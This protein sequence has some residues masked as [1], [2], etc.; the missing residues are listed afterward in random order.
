M[1]L[2]V[3]TPNLDID[4]AKI[5]CLLSSVPQ[6]LAVLAADLGWRPAHVRQI[7]TRARREGWPITGNQIIGYQMIFDGSRRHADMRG[8]LE[9]LGNQLYGGVISE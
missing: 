3:A 9:A 6:Q 5:L 2:D 7:I 8:E 4:R 1:R